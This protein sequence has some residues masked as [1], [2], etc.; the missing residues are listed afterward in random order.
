MKGGDKK[1]VDCVYHV[2]CINPK[3][4]RQKKKKSRI[5]I[6][7]GTFIE[8]C[9]IETKET[10][11]G[12]WLYFKDPLKQQKTLLYTGDILELDSVQYMIEQDIK[13][14]MNTVV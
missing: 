8:T 6:N 13:P 3:G 10:T 2:D 12:T 9:F 14:N 11:D 5:R 4:E 1:K 7:A